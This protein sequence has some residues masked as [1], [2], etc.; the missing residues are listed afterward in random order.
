MSDEWYSGSNI[1]GA[2]ESG[3]ICSVGAGVNFC[4][5]VLIEAL[6]RVKINE[7]AW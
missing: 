6:K 2:G 1:V 5:A 7:S 4:A 3:N